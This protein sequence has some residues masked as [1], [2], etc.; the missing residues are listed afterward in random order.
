ML[1]S[2]HKNEHNKAYEGSY[3]IWKTAAALWL[4]PRVGEDREFA[5]DFSGIRSY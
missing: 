1:S 5:R 4:I 3:V 2:C